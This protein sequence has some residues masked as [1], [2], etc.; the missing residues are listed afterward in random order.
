[1]TFLVLTF[2]KFCQLLLSRH[3]KF[4]RILKPT[5]YQENFNWNTKNQIGF[6]FLSDNQNFGFRLTSL[7]WA[8]SCS[9]GDP[10]CRDCA[11]RHLQQRGDGRDAGDTWWRRW[12]RPPWP[13]A[14]RLWAAAGGRWEE[15]GRRWA[16]VGRRR[17]ADG[18][19][20]W[21]TTARGRRTTD[22]GVGDFDEQRSAGTFANSCRYQVIVSVIKTRDR[23]ALVQLGPT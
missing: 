19:A 14:G 3:L 4:V 12:R 5:K 9:D 23:Q 6:G 2:G 16:A 17:D 13:A 7:V 20:I 1:M 21:G 18:A 8:C 10:S 15:V 22:G 11:E